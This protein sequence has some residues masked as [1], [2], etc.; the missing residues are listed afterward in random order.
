MRVLALLLL[1]SS[2]ALAQQ[3]T[4]AVPPLRVFGNPSTTVASLPTCNAG[5]NGFIYTITDALAPTI[6]GIVVGG[7]AVTL[8]V[9]CNG[10]NWIVA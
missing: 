7:G 6:A 10:T 2:T 3:A 1:L 5:A 4:I 8:M 9:H